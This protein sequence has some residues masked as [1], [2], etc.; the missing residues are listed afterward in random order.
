M[1]Y[2]IAFQIQ[3]EGAGRLA[4]VCMQWMPRGLGRRDA[5]LNIGSP[6]SQQNFQSY[7]GPLCV[8]TQELP[9]QIVSKPD[10]RT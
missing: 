10:I 6:A 9:T 1:V 5:Y 8:V 7:R 3:T 4:V 2:D